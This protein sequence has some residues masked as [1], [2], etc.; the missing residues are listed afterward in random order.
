M[1]AVARRR[2]RRPGQDAARYLVSKLLERAR[3][4]QVGTPAT[5]S[6]PYVNTIPPEEEPWFPG[7]EHLERRIRAFIRWNA[8]VMVSKANK[9]ADGIGG[10]LS[11][12]AS[13]ASL[14]DVGF[15]H[16]FR[17]KEDGLRRRRLHPGPR[18]PRHLR[19]GLPRGPPH[20]VRPRPVP[21]GGRRR[22]VALPPPPPPDARVLGVPHGVHGPR[23]HQLD[24]PRPVPALP[25][26]PPP[27][28]HQPSPV[29]C[30]VGDGEMDEPETLGR[31][32][33]RSRRSS[34]T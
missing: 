19:T 25:A 9:H 18:R 23:P 29:W 6:T 27:R 14:Y 21:S 20:R 16:F 2:R 8:A 22:H 24:L 5:V 13:S 10:H 30:F 11:T 32:R 33:S 1:A 12:F 15:N 17:G 3:E 4:L 28:R 26:Q 31:S 34:T 7:D